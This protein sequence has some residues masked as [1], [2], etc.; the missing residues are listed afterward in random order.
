MIS[1]IGLV[2]FSI[3][4]HYEPSKDEALRRFSEEEIIYAIP[5][6]SALV[7]DKGCLSF[8]GNV[9]VFQ[10]R[11]KDVLTPCEAFSP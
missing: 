8:M 2:G 3:K 4:A 7:F 6:R 1:G 11:E 9:Y 10:N 5:E